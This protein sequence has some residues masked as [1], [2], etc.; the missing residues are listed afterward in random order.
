[1]NIKRVKYGTDRK[2]SL[3]IDIAKRVAQQSRCKNKKVGAIIVDQKGENII[4]IGYN[5]TPMGFNNNCECEDG[6]TLDY[7]IHAEQNALMKLAKS[8]NSSYNAILFC[9]LS[10]CS[11]C[12]GMIIQAGISTVV[13]S[14]YY[15]CKQGLEL[16]D[17]AG[18]ELI[19][20]DE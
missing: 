18:I 17:L 13:F 4:G 5:G 6:T 9:T 2:I 7:V 12:A 19:K 8:G 16:L 20:V 3:F 10:P 11:K 1:M 15:K 14:E